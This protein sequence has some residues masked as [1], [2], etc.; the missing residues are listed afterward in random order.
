MAF[1][2]VV[3]FKDGTS[4]DTDPF[5]GNTPPL[6]G[7]TKVQVAG[8]SVLCKVVEVKPIQLPSAPRYDL[9]ETDEI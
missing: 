8:R 6:G 7:V 4:G 9:V 5:E 3:H 1:M 2:I